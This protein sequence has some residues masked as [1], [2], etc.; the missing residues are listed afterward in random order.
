VLV[1]QLP[2]LRERAGDV[3][4]LTDHFLERIARERGRKPP[5]LEREVLELLER[6]AWPGNVRQLENVL[7]RLSLL[8]GER[9]ITR[10]VLESDEGLRQVFLPRAQAAPLFSLEQTEREEIRKALEA[11]AGNR[12]RAARLLGISRATIYRKIREYRLS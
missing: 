10:E 2:A 8:A 1:V 7:Q 5:R 6:Y 11:A 9:A 12:D 3:A 4:L